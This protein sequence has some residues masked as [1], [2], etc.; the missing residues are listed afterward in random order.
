MKQVFLILVFIFNLSVVYAKNYYVNA[1]TGN[2]KFN[3]LSAGKAKST[4]Q[5][6]ANLTKPGDTV[7]VMNGTYINDCP[8]CNVTD[9]TKSGKR[10]RYIIYTNYPGHTPRVKFD[11]WAGLSVK[12]GTS[13]IKII[14]F[15]IIGNNAQVNLKKALNQPGGCKNKSGKYDPK[16]NGNG[17][18]IEGRGKKHSH[19]I[20][21][22]KNVVHDCGGGGIGAI[23]A[24]YITV[25]DNLVYNNSWYSV[26]G[27]SGI[28]L[29]Q[30]WNYDR[31]KGYHNYIRRN[32]CFNNNSFVPWFKTCEISDGN[33]IIIDDF[34]NWQK[35]S[36]LGRYTGQTLIEN[37]ICWYN[38]GTGIHS[39]Q[40]DN[41][42]IINNTAYCNS[43]S[44]GL[45][46][47]Q[48]LSGMGANNRIINNIL[49]SDGLVILN[50]NY[51]NTN[52]VYENNLHYNITNPD[53]AV[54]SITSP[55]CKYAD[56]LFIKPLRSLQANFQLQNTSP[57][58]EGGNANTYSSSDYNN[59][60]RLRGSR[61][62]IGA[63]EY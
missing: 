8:S 57:A 16:Y 19:H 26:F 61:S 51:S 14:G 23:Q 32:R 50:S 54:I 40:S 52:L 41:V 44:N 53:K 2:K 20:V 3:G 33:G 10:N 1:A 46:A 34:R 43:Q 47:G 31:A 35:S 56:P 4:I 13:Y 37:N 59:K 5:D 62:D 24:D 39:F 48:I 30:F 29:Y 15:E 18:S 25:E 58:I 17:I 49:I 38:G 28:S 11:G 6:A 55:S 63:Y 21:I 7:F 60:K 45:K 12:S 42:D 27:T 22:A 9:I 36:N